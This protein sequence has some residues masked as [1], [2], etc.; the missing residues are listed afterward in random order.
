MTVRYVGKGGN[1]SNNGLTWATR[2]LT[3]NGTEDTPVV[4]GDIVYVGPGT[5]RENLSVDV[6]GSLL[7]S[8]SASVVAFVTQGSPTV[9]VSGTNLISAGVGIDNIFQ[10]PVLANGSD[11]VATNVTG[12]VHTFT[13]A[14]GNFQQ[15]HVGYT[16]RILT[17]GAFII[18]SVSS[19]TS[20]TVSR[21]DNSS[22]G[23]PGGTGLTYVVGSESPYDVLRVDSGSQITLATNWEA[24][25]FSG[26]QFLIHRPIQYIGDYLGTNTDGIGGIVRV[27][28][29]DNDIIATRSNCVNGTARHYRIFKGF[30]FDTTTSIAVSAALGSTNWIIDRC[31]FKFPSVFK[32]LVFAGTGIGHCVQNSLF[33]EGAAM[34]VEFSHSITHTSNSIIQNS[35]FTGMGGSVLF[36]RVGGVLCRNLLVKGARGQGIIVST[37]IA[38]GESVTVNNSIITENS[39]GL[40]A[41]VAGEITE[42]F[43]ILFANNSNRSGVLS[44]A[45]SLTYPPFFDVRWFFQ[46]VYAGAGPY[47][48]LQFVSPFDLSSHSPLINLTGTYPPSTDM[49]G[50]PIQSTQREW[51]TLEYDPT[52]S[53]KARQAGMIGGGGMIIS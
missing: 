38:V 1:D 5:Y 31:V 33:M 17:I 40:S 18:R 47:N 45:N 14:A 49:R 39:T 30:L 26:I 29:S 23:M 8:G 51:G 19:R 53:I 48:A 20:I 36:T 27:T 21:P 3:L 52:L 44:G 43:N 24:S 25:S 50:T 34:Y 41:N 28:G 13:S 7:V 32:S 35:I 46:A 16:I 4:A 10:V 2:K 15:G 6:S 9:I 22:F 11:G 42:D 37:S 12:T